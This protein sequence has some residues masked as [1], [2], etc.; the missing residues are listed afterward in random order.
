[1]FRQAT[2]RGF[3]G[4]SNQSLD[5]QRRQ[6]GRRREDLHL[7]VG[8]VRHG[9]DRQAPQAVDSEYCQEDDQYQHQEPLGDGDPDQGVDHFSS[10]S[11]SWPLSSCDLSAKLP[12]MTMRSPGFNPSVTRLCL[13]TSPPSST[14]R[15]LK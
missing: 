6:R 12:L 5:L 2:H 1:Y 4:E 13:S 3:D 10:S 7:H 14:N 15:T 11:L 9:V 8:D